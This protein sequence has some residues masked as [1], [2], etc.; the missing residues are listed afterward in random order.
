MKTL[1]VRNITFNEGKPKICIPIMPKTIEE[2][3]ST[4][5]QLQGLPFDVVEWRMDHMLD[6]MN[7]CLEA[8]SMIRDL[9]GDVVLLSTF[10]TEQEGGVQSLSMNDYME[11]N[12]RIIDSHKSDFIDLELECSN[13]EIISYAH[14]KN[15]YIIMS[16][17]D[18][19]QTPSYED[20]CSRLKRMDGC[21]ADI[22]KLA[23]MPQ[24]S[25]DVLTLL[26]ATNDM[27]ACINKPI[28]TM[29]MGQLGVIS[30]LAG[31]T[32]GSC[33]TFGAAK[34]VSAPGQ[35]DANSL[36]QILNILTK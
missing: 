4:I 20:I 3:P 18:F 23:C 17:H 16:N 35:I 22:C 24:S 27:N 10:R 28:I 9:L 33:L 7:N 34:E 19:N 31:E 6:I 21:G 1:K 26:K 36:N 29:S 14:S 11:L 12:K 15:V 30:R 32:F 13:E 5:T 8:L 2:I 25:N